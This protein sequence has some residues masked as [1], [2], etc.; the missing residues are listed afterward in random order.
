MAGVNLCMISYHFEGKEGLYRACIE[1]FGKSR[2]QNMKGLLH[3]PESAQD[4]KVRLKLLISF[5]VTNIAEEP[6]LHKMLVR[7]MEAGLPIARDVFEKSFLVMFND[8]ISFFKSAQK[9][10]FIRSDLDPFFLSMT[11]YANVG[12]LLRTEALS[13][14]YFNRS[15]QDPKEREKMIDSLLSLIIHGT[16]L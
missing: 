5:L 12:H 15:I 13:A 6:E 14:H 16:S 10:H 7:E 9:A 11:I 4:F 1:E 2:V 3:K 8:M